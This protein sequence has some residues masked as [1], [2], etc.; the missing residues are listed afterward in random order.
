MGVATEVRK[1][2]LGDYLWIAR[3]KRPGTQDGLTQG[4]R[5]FIL[6]HIIERKRMDDLVRSCPLAL[7]GHLLGQRAHHWHLFTHFCLSP[8]PGGKHP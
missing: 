8:P 3:D 2:P 5:E 1:L 7:A 6:D 4:C